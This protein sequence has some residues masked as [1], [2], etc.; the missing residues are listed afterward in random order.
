MDDRVGSLRDDVVV[1]HRHH[2][3]AVNEITY[4]IG[5]DVWNEWRLPLGCKETDE[6]KARDLVDA[7]EA[8]LNETAP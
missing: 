5:E 3:Y 8:A 1:E 6:G 7:F 4:P 2:L